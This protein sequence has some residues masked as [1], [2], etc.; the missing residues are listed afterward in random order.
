MKIRGPTEL[1]DA[2]DQA[3][4]WRKHEIT[5]LHLLIKS[6]RRD[7]EKQLLIRATIPILYAHW[8]G[9]AKKAGEFYLQLV[10][11][12]G[13]PF[14]RLQTNFVALGCKNTVREAGHSNQLQLYINVVEF[15][16]FNQVI[17]AKFK[18]DGTIDVEDNLS[19]RVLANLL[20]IVGI[21]CDAFFTSRF[22]LIDGSL[23]KSRNEIAHGEDTELDEP[24]YDQLHSLV[25]ELMD[26]LKLAL[27]NAAV[28]K[29]YLRKFPCLSSAAESQ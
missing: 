11:M 14:N 8:E 17:Q 13:L 1:V 23:L 20:T 7:H 2:L 28:L 24:T 22:L 21:P 29:L 10:A 26:Y 12:Q 3:L 15:A 16:A 9:F 25:I 6:A 27:E 4:A 18:Y 19:S 5:N